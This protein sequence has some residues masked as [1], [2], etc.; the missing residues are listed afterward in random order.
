MTDYADIDATEIAQKAITATNEILGLM[1]LQAE[2]SLQEINGEGIFINIEGT[3]SH[4]IIGHH[5][6]T[7]NSLQLVVAIIANHGLGEGLRIFL[8]AEGYRDRRRQLLEQMAIMHANKA[9]ESGKEIVVTD[10]KPH[11]R[12]IVHMILADDPEVETYSEGAGD[13]RH[14]VISPKV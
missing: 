2:A 11:E 12:R 3:D 10:L 8:D 1:G 9:K 4:H 7:L 14:L 5:G 13:D 6:A